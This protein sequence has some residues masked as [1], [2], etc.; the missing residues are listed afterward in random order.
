MSFKGVVEAESVAA[1]AE[2]ESEIPVSMVH[3]AAVGAP[4][5]Q[6]I[7]NAQYRP[8]STYIYPSGRDESGSRLRIIRRHIYSILRRRAHSSTTFQDPC[9]RHWLPRRQIC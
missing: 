8:S 6:R 4:D 7:D 3:D 1:T 2:R 5:H 9:L